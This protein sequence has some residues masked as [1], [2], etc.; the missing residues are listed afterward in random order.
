MGVECGSQVT[1]CEYP[2]HFDTYKGCSHG[3]AYCF[4]KRKSNIDEIEASRSVKALESFIAGN[5]C[6]DTSW[7]DWE[8]PIHWGGVS[9]PF[10]PLESNAGASLEALKVLE[11]T[12]YPFIVSTKGRLVCEEPYLSI[13][14]RCNAVVQVSA[15]CSSYD[16][17]EQG[18]PTYD[19]RVE[20][21]SKLSKSVKRVVVRVQPYMREIKNE[22]ISNLQRLKDAGAYGIT[23]E[24]MK[25]QSKRP[26]LE[27]VG[28]DYCY[29][30]TALRRDYSQIRAECKKVGLAFFC[31]E[32]RLRP[33]GDST[34]CCGCGDIDGFTGN[35][36]NAVNIVNGCDVKPTEA[37][38]VK[39]TAKC[40]G[41]V[42][43]SPVS[44]KAL[45]SATFASQM[46][47]EAKK[48]AK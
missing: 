3:C 20:M 37:M 27:K 45:K 33:M 12:G 15:V 30:E 6:A 40:F 46:L 13:L 22:L 1:V 44:N 11:R 9:D 18:A 36:F 42:Y 16:K 5:R 25:F 17:L 24:G 2:V 4:V 32:N 34:S 39:G 31:A 8:I 23:V 10:Q 43:Q 41:G 7:C 14:S 47:Y 28:G 26:G 35:R 29:P 38:M 48:L 19:E 21:I